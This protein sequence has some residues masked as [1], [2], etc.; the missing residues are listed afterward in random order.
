M[1]APGADGVEVSE[2]F[3]G[4]LCGEGFPVE[5]LREGIGEVLKHGEADEDGVAGR[6]RC[7]LVAEDAEL[8]GEMRTLGGDGGV[9]A[10]GVELEPVQLIWRKSGDGAV[11]GGANLED[12]LSAVVGE[13]A[14]AEDL[15]QFTG[16]VAAE[17]VHLP[18][19]VLCGDEALRED[20]VVEVCGADVWDSLSVALDGDGSGESGDGERAVD[21]RE[22]VAQG[23][24]S[25]V[26]S[27]EEGDG[28]EEEEER[29]EDGDGTEEDAAATAGE[30]APFCVW[31]VLFERA[32]GEQ[33]RLRRVRIVGIHALV[34][35]LNGVRAGVSTRRGA[36]LCSE[37][38][39]ADRV[40]ISQL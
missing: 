2:K 39:D 37:V 5:L 23:F 18:E 29:E 3:G 8:D 1:V 27:A 21:L 26:S 6:P 7:G 32:A 33:C 13:E 38:P 24:A 11:G 10:S 36:L 14:V 34:Q 12:A 25:P 17:D 31:R 30:V 40:K 20:E 28:C 4:K 35:S 15:S 9:D 16:G 19:P 22:R